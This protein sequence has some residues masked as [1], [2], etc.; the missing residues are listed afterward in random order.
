MDLRSE[1]LEAAA[2]YPDYREFATTNSEHPAYRTVV[3]RI[4]QLIEEITSG[5]G[6]DYKVKGSTGAGNVTAAPWVAVL[7][8]AVTGK[9][10]GGYYVVYLYSVDLQSLFLSLAFGV[11]AF[12]DLHGGSQRMKNIL[13]N[14][15]K[16]RS[17]KLELP[18]GVVTGKISLDP[19]GRSKLHPLYELSSIAAFEYDL[20]KMPSNDSLED[21]LGKM[22][23]LY[24]EAWKKWGSD[25]DERVSE[26]AVE[27]KEIEAVEEGFV[28]R[29]RPTKTGRKGSGTRSRYSKESR[30]VGNSG[31]WLVLEME[32]KKLIEAQRPDLAERIVHEADL[33]NYPGYD[34]LSYNPDG[35][36]RCIEVKASKGRISGVIMTNNEK[37]AAEELGHEFVLAIVENVFKNPTI[38]YLSNPLVS[39]G[40]QSNPSPHS[41]NFHLWKE[42]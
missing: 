2:Q 7:D 17:S 41:W 20:S 18:E 38:Q 15:A 30:K 11:T 19:D 34:I 5:R 4:P 10:T 37:N 26:D 14:S 27:E 39:L 3:R 24:Y 29:N 42:D 21:D 12:R 13:G 25:V 23:D 32:K 9:P 31:E 6:R 35:S 16:E 36:R 1:L 40:G 8:R 33:G 28:A 22:L